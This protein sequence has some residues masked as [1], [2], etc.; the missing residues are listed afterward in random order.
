[1]LVTV[2]GASIDCILDMASGLCGE[3]IFFS[4]DYSTDYKPFYTTIFESL[5]YE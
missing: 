4:H 2:L 1:V 5:R 3:F